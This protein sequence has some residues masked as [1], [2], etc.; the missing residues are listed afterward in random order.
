[1]TTANRRRVTVFLFA[2]LAVGAALGTEKRGVIDSDEHWRAEN[3]PFVITDD[4]LV[5]RGARLIITPGT[6]VLVDKPVAYDERFEQRDHLDSFTVS[7]RVQGV[8]QCVGR[9]D[10]RITIV[11][12]KADS[13]KCSW[14]GIVLENQT[15][16][17]SEIAFTD[18]AGSCHGVVAQN[19]T[20]L[21]RNAVFEFNNVG[22][23]SLQ[24]AEPRVYNCIAAYNFASGVRIEEAN[25]VL[26][27]NIIVF[28][29]NNGV[30]SDGVSR[31]RLKYN[32]IYG[33]QDGNLRGCDPELGILSEENKNGDSTDYAHNLFAEPVF[34]GTKADS[35]A[36]E[37]DVNL[38]T[39]KSRVKDTVLA[40]AMH[41]TLTDSTASRHL[42]GKHRRY[43][44]STYSPCIDAGKPGKAFR[45]EDGSRNDM[46]IWGGQEFADFS[47]AD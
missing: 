31:F 47:S 42:A 24:G 21:I 5:A 11:S 14:Y 40:K 44:L 28:N 46:G 39:D 13:I 41:G 45:D 27:G 36:V 29:R 43:W 20:P 16:N 17:F 33:N 12:H 37:H 32:C 9:R 1:M 6:V 7:I 25:P 38:P 30:W 4:V 18:V 8:L 2:L 15:N 10:N 26:Y 3:G 23:T 22:L 34:A 19:C 35:I